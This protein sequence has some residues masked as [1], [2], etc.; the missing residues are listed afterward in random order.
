M[1]VSEIIQN[2]FI[3]CNEK[4]HG[5][6]SRFVYSLKKTAFTAPEFRNLNNYAIIGCKHNHVDGCNI[7][8][9][10]KF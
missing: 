6:K 4:T 5:T 8:A 1:A 3:T 7:Y 2:Q 9:S 10:C